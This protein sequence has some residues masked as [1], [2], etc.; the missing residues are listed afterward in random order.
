MIFHI[1]I[2]KEYKYGQFY[3]LIKH[4]RSSIVIDNE[5]FS[6]FNK[7]RIGKGLGKMH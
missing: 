6:C 1:N 7:Y 3:Y 4:V 2:I 5:C